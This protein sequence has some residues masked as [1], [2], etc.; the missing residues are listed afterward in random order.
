MQ[1]I[2]RF[3]FVCLCGTLQSF[4]R[5]FQRRRLNWDSNGGSLC[6]SCIPLSFQWGSNVFLCY[7]KSVSSSNSITYKAGE[8][9]LVFLHFNLACRS[10]WLFLCEMLCNCVCMPTFLCVV[11][12]HESR[13]DGSSPLPRLPMGLTVAGERATM[14]IQQRSRPCVS[15]YKRPQPHPNLT[16]CLLLWDSIWG[17]AVA[18]ARP[19]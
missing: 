10:F 2:Y 8:F 18:S 1:S 11:A 6:V 3:P 15:R 7:K 17:T 5:L 4:K 19:F 16:E 9:W 13:V 12:C 14:L